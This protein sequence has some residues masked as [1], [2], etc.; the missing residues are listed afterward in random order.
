[1]NRSL[2]PIL[3]LYPDSLGANLGDAVSLLRSPAMQGCFRSVYILPSLFHTD[4]DRGFSLADYGLE[5]T[6]CRP[7]DLEALRADGLS[8]VLDFLL[9][10]LSM[11]SP[12][13]QDL[14]RRGDDSPY[15][16]FFLDWNRFWA[17]HGTMT[18]AGYL[19]PEPELLREMFFRKPGLP[20]LSVRFPDGRSVP[21]WNTFYQE[22][23]H[24]PDGSVDYLGQMDLNI[25]SPLVWEHYRETLETLAGYGASL[26]RLDAFAYAH[27]AVGQRNFLNEP[28]TWELLARLQRLAVPLGL[29]LLP[30]IH[31]AYGEGVYE[32][33]ARQGCPVYD[34]F[35]PGLIL[36]AL[37]QRSGAML[38]HWA[39]ELTEKGIST[40]N[41]LG[42]HDG[43]PLLDL[44]GLLPEERIQALIRTVVGRGGFVKDLHGQTSLYYQVNA[45]Y[46]SAL[47]EEDRRLLLA[48]AIQLFM[49]G[50]PQI[51]Y[52]DLF[53]GQNDYAAMA[54]AGAGG[55]KE[56]NRSSL[57]LQ[58]AERRLNWAVVRQQ[59]A[60]LRMRCSF[61]VFSA[62][63]HITAEAVGAGLRLRWETAEQT[64]VLDADLADAAFTIRISSRDGKTLFA[65]RDQEAAECKSEIRNMPE[66]K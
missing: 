29:T 56:L 33:L 30:E 16:D 60:L 13:F 1:M 49:P 15:R 58:E 17:G 20:L 39:Q 46:Y 62:G 2:A 31:A 21:Y 25:R 11:R 40:V 61:P 28:G 35:L 8:L 34:F 19:Q 42:C 3:N 14:L 38:C 4:L 18:P 63:A 54:R 44:R 24:L 26:V 65:F 59:L 37:E 48:R 53:R 55:H 52:L 32:K 50:T 64:A 43:I 36:D 22:V 12:Q 5:E 6:L 47:G 7:A 57:S 45:A 41:M 51:W 9:N 27:K 66:F 23:Q 10:H